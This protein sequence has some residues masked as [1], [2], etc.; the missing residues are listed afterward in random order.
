MENKKCPC[1]GE[2]KPASAFGKMSLSSTGLQVYCKLCKK[3]KAQ[4][5]RNK[6]LKKM[7]EKESEYRKQNHEAI[8][9]NSKKYYDANKDKISAYREANIER[10]KAYFKAYLQQDS[11]RLKLLVQGIKKRAVRKGLEFDITEEDII[12]HTVCPV[13]GVDL[14]FA[15]GSRGGTSYSLS[16]DRI[17]SNRGYTKDNIQVMSRLAN[18]MKNNATPEQLLMFADWIIKTYRK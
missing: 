11:N 18:V 17:D 6:N 3:T 13:F 14:V 15:T 8:Q 2:I 9:K 12:G 5:Y 7:L 1:C 16:V 10:S 4:E